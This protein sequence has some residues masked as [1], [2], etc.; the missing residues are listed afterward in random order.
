MAVTLK[1]I[2][3]KR[4]EVRKLAELRDAAWNDWQA[5]VKTLEI[6]RK[7][8][9]AARQN[10]GGAYVELQEL[11]AVFALD[12]GEDAIQEKLNLPEQ[13]LPEFVEPPSFAVD[14]KKYDEEIPF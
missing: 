12:E 7:A 14:E 4:A 6:T 9:A 11:G 10:Y 3:E 8:E 2:R 5:A 13:E 1:Q